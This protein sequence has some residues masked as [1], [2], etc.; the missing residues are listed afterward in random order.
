MGKGEFSMKIT[1]L[2]DN[3]TKGIL[4][5]EWGLSLYIDYP[6]Y[7]ILLDTGASDRFAKNAKRLG[8]DLSLV[9]FGVLSHAHYD[10][11]DGL[12]A[13][14]AQ[15]SQAPFY[16][17]QGSKEN[18][19]GKRW[20]FRKYIGIHRGF[21][22]TYKDRI[23]YVTDQQ[24]LVK[25]VSLLGHSTEGLEAFGMQNN[26]YVRQGIR[27]L[28]DSFVHEQSL[29]LDTRE[30]LVILSSCSHA[31]ADNIIE[32]V[33]RAYPQKKIYAMIGGFHLYHTPETEVRALAKRIRSTGIQKI[34]TG[35]CTKEPAFQIL[36]E[37][38]GEQAHQLYTGMEI[39]I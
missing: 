14:F 29:L 36:K 38:L 24:E 3:L 32:E 25:G 19:Y 23:L 22:N 6:P 12:G 13:F 16:L 39:V 2:I 26:L 4:E 20:I 1:V 11:A 15:N 7:R 35:H 27:Y 17:R 33:Q 34:Y 21:L 8:I 9:D 5:A 30:G 31:G 10:H 18:C 37:E 28:P